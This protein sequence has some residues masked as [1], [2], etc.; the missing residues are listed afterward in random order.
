[1]VFKNSLTLL[2]ILIC[3]E[4]CLTVFSPFGCRAQENDA[5]SET[6]TLVEK[7]QIPFEVNGKEVGKTSIPA[8]TKVTVV[9]R[10]GARV[11]IKRGNLGPVWVEASQ[12]SGLSDKK[13]EQPS[14]PVKTDPAIDLQ[15]LTRLVSEKKW[16]QV[17]AACEAMAQADDKFAGL[18]E[19]A[20]QL[21]SALQAQASAVQQQKNAETEAQRLRRNADVVGQPSRL[22]PNDRSPMERAQKLRDEAD[23]V[24]EEAQNNF[25]EAQSRIVKIGDDISSQISLFGD[26]GKASEEDDKPDI[27]FAA[28]ATQQNQPLADQA[29]ALSD[30]KIKRPPPKGPSLE[31]K[32]FSLNLS[33]SELLEV[34]KKRVGTD[35]ITQEEVAFTE[36]PLFSGE[37][38][39]LECTSFS[40]NDEI[41]GC[42]ATWDASG[43]GHM[44]RLTLSDPFVSDLF[45]SHGLDFEEFV[46]QFIT[47][48]DIERLK[49]V[50]SN[51]IGNEYIV[52]YHDSGLGW[53]IEIADKPPDGP[54]R[55]RFIR[56]FRVEPAPPAP[57]TTFGD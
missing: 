19:L 18:A 25:T 22:N 28:D 24:V 34:L 57:Q 3:V 23:A 17:A 43:E 55:T 31:F 6:V 46:R 38:S 39:R 8:G 48:Y 49:T 44:L 16:P 20:E 32:G 47:A 56:L 29:S 12:L 26:K 7:V 10:D 21:K 36:E 52:A 41:V 42:E 15:T 35:A 13:P 50:R 33:R 27:A 37:I 1:M 45:N 40:I 54:F 5:S 14:T 9:S 53:A 11:S 4:S 51:E 2:T 30:P